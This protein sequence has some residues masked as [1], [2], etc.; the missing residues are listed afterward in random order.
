VSE[1]NVEIV[2]RAYEAWA[3]RDMEAVRR[4][5]DPDITW[6]EREAVPDPAIH[7]GIAAVIAR[8]AELDAV[9]TGLTL[10]P[11]EFID[12]DPCVVVSFCL[13]GRGRTSGAAV[14]EREAHVVRLWKRKLVELRA[15]GE[16]GDALKAVGLEE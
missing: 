3:R 10:E 1:E 11:Q 4:A 6:S 13:L 8:L 15:Y 9:W 16:R 2:Q 7:R 12:A 5:C 14:E